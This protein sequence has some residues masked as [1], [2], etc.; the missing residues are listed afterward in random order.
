VSVAYDDRKLTVIEQRTHVVHLRYP[1]R[2][3][4]EVVFRINETGERLVV[5][6]SHWPSRRRGRYESEPSRIALA[7]NLAFLV[8]NHLRFDAQSYLELRQNDDLGAVR[9]RWE[10]PILLMGDFND[11][12]FDRSVVD[13]LQ[14]SSEQ[15]RVVGS[16]NDIDRFEK[17]PADYT[18]GD[19]FLYNACWKFLDPENTGTFFLASTRQG[20]AFANRYQV[21]H[22]FVVSR[23]LLNGPGLRLEVDSVQIVREARVATPSGRPGAFRRETKK[24]TSDHLPITA[25]LTY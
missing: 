3:I 13:H 2:D 4:F 15:D 1:T 25:V 21:L 11:E 23:G 16:T 6:A 14:A 17:E 5:L 12:P 24:G 22:Q 8:R 18:G 20:E 19:I 10:T 9:A 7:E